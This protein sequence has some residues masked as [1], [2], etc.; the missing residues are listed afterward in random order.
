MINETDLVNKLVKDYYNINLCQGYVLR[1]KVG[2]LKNGPNDKKSQTEEINP[3]YL[4]L[5][6]QQG[7]TDGGEVEDRM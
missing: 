2:F 4:S 3:T 6:W 5:T 7:R 1:G